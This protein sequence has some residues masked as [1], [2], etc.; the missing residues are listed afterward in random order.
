MLLNNWIDSLPTDDL[1][2]MLY[3]D[4]K[5]LIEIDS[6]NLINQYK[7]AI[8]FNHRIYKNLIEDP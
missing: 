3:W 8:A 4:K 2:N 6:P 5:E 1:T 7:S